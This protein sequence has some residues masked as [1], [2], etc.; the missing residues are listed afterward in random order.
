MFV[1]RIAI[2]DAAGDIRRSPPKRDGRRVGLGRKDAQS[3]NKA[4]SNLSIV[5]G[6]HEDASWRFSDW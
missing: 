6:A 4:S 3:K 5:K 2:N 1:E